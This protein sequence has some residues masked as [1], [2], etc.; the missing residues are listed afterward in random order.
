MRTEVQ[1]RKGSAQGKT[2][3]Q[4]QQP[5]R[6]IRDAVRFA[7]A[8]QMQD[9]P[10]TPR[11]RVR[12]VR[13]GFQRRVDESRRRLRRFVHLVRE[14]LSYWRWWWLDLTRAERARFRQAD[15]Q[16]QRM[17]KA[18]ARMR[19]G[20]AAGAFDQVAEATEE[21]RDAAAEF[22]EA[23]SQAMTPRDRRAADHV[24]EDCQ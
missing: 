4:V 3:G 22:S 20:H 15:Q 8:T 10:P 7:I 1:V 24:P 14:R 18:M 12:L 19:D 11:E 9:W 23:A 13:R 21:L 17:A 2:E 6:T 5:N 16:A